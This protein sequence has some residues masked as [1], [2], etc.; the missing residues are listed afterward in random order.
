MS[1]RR[2]PEGEF[3]KGGWVGPPSKARSGDKE[4]IT[5]E[6]L[7]EVRESGINL[8]Y[9]TQEL[10][11][12]P[13]ET[14]RMIELADEAGVFLMMPDSRVIGEDFDVNGFL[15]D[16]EYYKAHKSVLGLNFC[17]EPGLQHFAVIKKNCEKLK[18]HLGD[19]LLY[20]NHMPMYAT[21]GQLSGGWWT[22][23]YGEETDIALYYEFMDEFYRN[24]DINMVSYDFYP[25]RHERGSCDFHYF[26]QLYVGRQM[27]EKYGKPLWNF[28]QVTSWNRDCVRNITYEEIAWLNNTSIACGVTGLQYFCY[29]TP[30]DGLE[31]F[32]NAMIS[33][34]GYKTAHYYFVRDLNRKLD[35]IAPYILSARYKGVIAYGDTLCY[36]PKDFNLRSFGNLE[37]VLSNGMLVGCFEKDG[38]YMYY[39][40]NT[41]VFET[42]LCEL[43][44]KSEI[45][46]KI[47]SGLE[48]TAWD[49]D[50][51]LKPIAP[52]EAILVIEE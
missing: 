33:R 15:P 36:F 3:I 47:I 16:L 50:A 20:V 4:Y 28:T 37:H 17:D 1:T 26:E 24:I 6:R 27:A 39:V 8:L 12:E 13:D 45:R 10:W 32:E 23:K 2:F 19:L 49:G 46:A 7:K 40:V 31:V 34:D 44:F 52:G 21:P 35:K 41:S 25:F 22:E 11:K 30:C 48:E 42:R 51:L 14:K 38:K 43:Y 9:I 18:P 29:W 5:A